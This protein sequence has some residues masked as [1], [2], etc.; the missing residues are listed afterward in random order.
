MQFCMWK[1]AKSRQRLESGSSTDLVLTTDEQRQFTSGDEG[2]WRDIMGQNLSLQQLQQ[3]GPIRQRLDQVLVDL[4]PTRVYQLGEVSEKKD[5]PAEPL[6]DPTSCVICL[7][8]LADGD[9]LR[10][11]PCCHEYHQ[12]CI[13]VWLTKRNNACPLCLALVEIPALPED[14]H[15]S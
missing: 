2:F 15:H 13:D 11:L 4:L 10:R 3:R 5:G 9:V 8:E 7:E 6:Y 12:D 1:L 14:C